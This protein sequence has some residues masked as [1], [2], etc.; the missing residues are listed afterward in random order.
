MKKTSSK[1]IS[2]RF[3]S[4][5][6]L[7]KQKI[8]IKFKNEIISITFQVFGDNMVFGDDMVVVKDTRSCN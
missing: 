5:E 3:M 8:K 6:V 2:V 4:E 7:K 1:L